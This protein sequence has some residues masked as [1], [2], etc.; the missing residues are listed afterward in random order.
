MA[1]IPLLKRS[2][3]RKE[4]YEYPLE[5]REEGET[6]ILFSDV[7]TNGIAYLNLYFD[8][9]EVPQEKLFYLYL[10][11]DLIGG[12]STKSHSYE[13][14]GKLQDLHTGGISYDAGVNTKKDEPDSFQPMLK[15]RAKALVGK[16]PELFSLLRE[17]L[18]ESRFTD[19]KRVKE[20]MEQ[21]QV[22]F[23]MSMQ[24]SAHNLVAGRIAG[25]LSPSGRYAEEGGLPFYRFV[26]DFLANF[27]D[28][29]PSLQS[30]MEELMA[31]VFNRR[32]LLVSVTMK[33]KDY[34]SFAEVLP[35]LAE[36]LSTEKFPRAEYHWDMDRENAG[37]M[38]A[39]RVQ[40]VGKGANFMKLGHPFTGV[41]HV[42]E[43]V[44]RYDYFWTRIRVQGGAYGAFANFNRN[45]TMFFGSY[46]DPNLRE[47]LEI[48]DGTGAYVR[49]FRVSD[50][51]MDKFVIGTMS[52][53]DMPLTPKM[54]GNLAAE[55]WLRGITREDRQKS[56]DQILSARQQDIRALADTVDD[57]MK[58][59]NLCVF[60]N[61][62]KLKENREC[63]GSLLSVME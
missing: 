43:T 4:A 57:C 54:K 2:D 38:S 16:L 25:G 5:E 49:D 21:T 27:D 28:R 23:E 40:Y 20:L 9:S 39:S 48:F 3:I 46:R 35:E 53:V 47:T 31:R 11:A 62:E 50:R 59:N 29:F 44:L 17:I 30:V 51:E 15:V 63:F 7:E 45:G 13:E 14:L 55:C 33:E 58:E 6:K 36:S 24:R 22:S 12:V 32:G 41:M 19:R 61:E 1:T 34:P 42:L 18:T 8:T 10:L 56:R 26:K 37:L 60:G 52:N